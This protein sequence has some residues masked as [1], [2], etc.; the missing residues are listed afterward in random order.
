MLKVPAKPQG[1]GESTRNPLGERV[2]GE[3]V[4]DRAD[5]PPRVAH[6]RAKAAEGEG[7]LDAARVADLEHAA[8][9]RKGAGGCEIP[10]TSPQFRHSIWAVSAS[11]GV[12]TNTRTLARTREPARPPVKG[13]AQGRVPVGGEESKQEAPEAEVLGAGDPLVLREPLPVLLKQLEQPR[14]E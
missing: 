7:R 12:R 13:G 4:V 3:G 14:P 10:P 1:C 6:Q 9:A 11:T 8:A 5:Q 2:A